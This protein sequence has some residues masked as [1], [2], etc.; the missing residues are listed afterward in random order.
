MCYFDCRNEEIFKMICEFDC[1]VFPRGLGANYEGKE[2]VIRYV[3]DS[4][5]RSIEKS[6]RVYRS[7]SLRR[8]LLNDGYIDYLVQGSDGLFYSLIIFCQE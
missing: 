4:S 2:G 8:T 6:V 5:G 7:M 1:I 3:C